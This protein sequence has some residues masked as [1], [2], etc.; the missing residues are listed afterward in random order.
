LLAFHQNLLF[1]LDA[2]VF[3]RD[4]REVLVRPHSGI[5][6]RARKTRGIKNKNM[7]SV[8]KYRG[9]GLLFEPTEEERKIVERA[10]SFVCRA[11][12]DNRC[13]LLVVIG[14]AI[15]P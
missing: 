2:P 3:G 1:R 11:A 8:T 12:G 14:A 6:A 15:S 9:R 4:H 7:G 10:V 5:N 13:G